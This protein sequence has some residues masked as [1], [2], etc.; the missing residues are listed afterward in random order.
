MLRKYQTI[1]KHADDQLT[2]VRLRSEMKFGGWELE[3]QV[4]DSTYGRLHAVRGWE[5][6][7]RYFSGYV[8][9]HFPFCAQVYTLWLHRPHGKLTQVV[10]I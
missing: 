1:I 5:K 3:F 7:C 8:G 10:D 2:W 9:N 4:T 6:E